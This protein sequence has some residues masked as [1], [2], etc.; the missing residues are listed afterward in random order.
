M[1]AC[2]STGGVYSCDVERNAAY[3]KGCRLSSERSN[4]FDWI[5]ASGR[6]PTGKNS[7]RS[8]GGAVYPSTGPTEA[9]NGVNYLLMEATSHAGLRSRCDRAHDRTTT[10]THARKRH[11]THAH[12][13]KHTHMHTHGKPIAYRV[14]CYTSLCT[15][16]KHRY[17]DLFKYRSVSFFTVIFTLV[18]LI[19]SHG[20]QFHSCIVR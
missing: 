12:D 1:C 11:H 4:Q 18:A 2:V 19:Q 14:S 8:L 20:S 15:I 3:E 6:T 7:T 16:S 5:A 13:R 9:A 17:P 10:R